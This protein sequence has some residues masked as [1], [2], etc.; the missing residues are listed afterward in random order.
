MEVILDFVLKL[1]L[2]GFAFYLVNRIFSKN[3]KE[4]HCKI[5]LSGFEL[6]SE[7]YENKDNAES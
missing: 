7:F 1:A 3:T 2:L 4:L 6:N 5:D